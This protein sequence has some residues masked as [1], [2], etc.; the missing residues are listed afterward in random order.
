[1]IKIFAV[2]AIAALLMSNSCDGTGADN[3]KPEKPAATPIIETTPAED[4]VMAD[5]ML[6]EE[7][8]EPGRWAWSG[9][10]GPEY[11]G[12]LSREFET[13]KIGQMQSPIDLVKSATRIGAVPVALS[14]GR[15]PVEVMSYQDV[16]EIHVSG[17]HQMQAG[18]TDWRLYNI[19]LHTPAMHRFDNIQYPAEIHFQHVDEAGRQGVLAVPVKVGEANAPLGMIM[20]TYLPGLQHAQKADAEFALTDLVPEDLSV[21]HYTGSMVRPPC[22]EG[23]EWF[24]A[25]TPLTASAEQ[26]GIIKKTFRP[27]ARPV[28][29]SNGRD[30]TKPE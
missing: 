28:Q 20:G 16:L 10:K 4:P 29:P 21:Y 2:G 7:I 26:L 8:E 19:Y 3:Q 14:Y 9:D 15:V 27:N 17:E 13:C 11:W 5:E 25:A 23:V 12:D 1:M 30:V 24:V 22:M 18:E 6:D